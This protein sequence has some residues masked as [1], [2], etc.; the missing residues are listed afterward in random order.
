M[1]DIALANEERCLW[2]H[3]LAQAESFRP[4][5]KFAPVAFESFILSERLGG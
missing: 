3:I 4:E 5:S 1:L 2:D